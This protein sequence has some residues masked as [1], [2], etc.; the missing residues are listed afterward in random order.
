LP[1]GRKFCPKTSN[2]AEERNRWQ[3]KFDGNFAKNDRF[4]T[5]MLPLNFYFKYVES[6]SMFWHKFFKKTDRTFW[7]DWPETYDLTWQQS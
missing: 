1:G 6:N 7:C 2:V 3:E 5:L 4:S